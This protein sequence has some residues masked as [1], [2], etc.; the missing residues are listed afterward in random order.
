MVFV[1]HSYVE[2]ALNVVVY[3]FGDVSVDLMDVVV[4]VADD[5]HEFEFA[6]ELALICDPVVSDSNDFEV[7]D[8]DDLTIVSVAVYCPNEDLVPMYSISVDNLVGLIGYGHS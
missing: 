5:C 6:A 8:S 2:H 3:D 1:E 4:V 7:V